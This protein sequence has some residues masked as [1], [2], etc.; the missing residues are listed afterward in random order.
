VPEIIY[1]KIYACRCA[2][3]QTLGDQLAWPRLALA[4]PSKCCAN[5]L[6]N[7]HG[8]FFPFSSCV[9]LTIRAPLRTIRSDHFSWAG[10]FQTRVGQRLQDSLCVAL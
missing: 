4:R 5:L 7:H 6:G 3:N 1:R 8:L 2:F 9:F 10:A